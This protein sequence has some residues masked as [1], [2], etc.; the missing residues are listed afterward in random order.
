M[1]ATSVRACM[2]VVG[3]A[4]WAACD[5]PTQT[6][7]AGTPELRAALFDTLLAQTARR[8]AFSPPKEAAM[9]YSPLEEMALLRDDFVAADTEEE[10]YYALVRL[11][12]AR[13]DHHLD[14]TPVAGG[15]RIPDGPVLQAPLRVLGDFTGMGENPAFESAEFFV[16]AIDHDA[17]MEAES[18]GWARTGGIPEPGDRIVRVDGLATAEF[19]EEFEQYIP[20]SSWHGKLWDLASIM[21][22]RDP[23][24]VPE[25][26]Y[27]A[28]AGLELE[29]ER[30]DG[31]RYSTT[32]PYLDAD[33]VALPF[34]DSPMYPGFTTVLEQQNFD[35]LLPDDGRPVVLL[36]WL[37]FEEEL[38]Q[39]VADLIELAE[40]RDLLG[41]TLIIDVTD[42]SGGSGGAYAIQRLVS[43]PFMTTFGNLRLSDAGVRWIE[44]RI[45]RG[46]DEDAPEL[47]GMDPSG[48][49][50][51]EWL[52]TDVQESIERGDEYTNAVPF[53]SAHLPKDSDGILQPAPVHFTGPIAILDGPRGGSHLDQ[54]VSMFADNGL[55]RTVGMPAGGYSNTWEASEVVTMGGDPEGQP[56][57]EF[58]WNIGHTLRP[59]GE[60]L[61][62]NPVMP[63][64]YIPLTRENFR[65]YHQELFDAAIRLLSTR[66]AT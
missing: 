46:I 21:T 19:I 50:L 22:R 15:L 9:A 7:R 27:D 34:A 54:F 63:E 37:D 18:S 43:R 61:E 66:P 32:V 64:L 23:L 4:T 62:G 35:V 12:N 39:D 29:L 65:T 5:A 53:K 26:L 6:S 2:L 40:E 51:I 57:A 48:R 31:E 10:L 25:S 8:E 58:M 1:R 41:H 52:T 16:S 20:Y 45:E 14:V 30:M 17:W 49:W 60:I 28:D 33:D 11:S 3:A 55:A 47:F 36:R 44:Q 38:V 24:V 56:V 59:T 42:S 13:R